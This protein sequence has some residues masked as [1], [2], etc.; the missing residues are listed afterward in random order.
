MTITAN[1]Q[2]EVAGRFTIPAGIPAGAKQVS[3]IGT[4]SRAD[5][6]FIGEGTVT[7]LT[8]RST[9]TTHQQDVWTKGQGGG[10]WRRDSY[11]GGGFW[12]MGGSG[13]SAGVWTPDGWYWENTGETT[14]FPTDNI[15]SVSA[16]GGDA[17][18]YTQST[19]PQ[20]FDPLAQTFLL[21]TTVQVS[22]LELW[23]TAKGTGSQNV[24]VQIRPCENGVPSYG[25]IAQAVLKPEDITLNTWQRLTFPPATIVA[26]QEYAIIVGAT[27]S[28]SAIAVANMGEYDTVAQQWV[29]TQPYQIG[30]ML[31][32]SNNLTWTPHQT[33]DLAFRLLANV[34]PS[35]PD[36]APTRTVTLDPID[37]VDAD[38][39]I[40]LA[41]VDRPGTGCQVVFNITAGGV[42]YQAVENQVVTLQSRFTGELTWTVTLTG[43]TY[44]SPKIHKDLQ[45]IAGKRLTSGTY[46]TAAL[47]TK[48]G[49]LKLSVDLDVYIDAY[50]PSGSSLDVSA[51]IGAAWEDLTLVESEELGE[52]WVELHYQLEGITETQ[53]RLQLVLGGTA[54]SRPG[55]CNLRAAM[56]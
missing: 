12:N 24:L 31:S 47:D 53:T 7:L 51:E 39:L 38:Q 43:T 44:T 54:V 26:N 52:S 3:F 9:V 21:Q 37:V 23:F 35:E 20:V 36:Q 28:V 2:G 16:L 50:L 49:P 14:P 34:Y 10:S 41:T 8:K 29:T 22:A 5:A 15:A 6:T 19:G 11:G 1:A 48:V 25:V 45:L 55:V 13:N 40:V 33:S 4:A 42:T 27:D 17:S 32:S 46:I 56:T 30:V 18:A